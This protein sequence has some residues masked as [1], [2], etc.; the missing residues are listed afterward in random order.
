MTYLAALNWLVLKVFKVLAPVDIGPV[1][2]LVL[3]Y[4]IPPA[5][6]SIISPLTIRSPSISLLKANSSPSF[7]GSHITLP[8]PVDFKNK[9]LVRWI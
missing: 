6:Y 1:N 9:S 4:T 7:I 2:T 3:E 5:A 8:S